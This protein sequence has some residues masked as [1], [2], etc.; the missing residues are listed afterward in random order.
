MYTTVPGSVKIAMS[1]AP[2][3]GKSMS[4]SAGVV[5][6]QSDAAGGEFV[7]GGGDVVAG[8]AQAGVGDADVD[9]AA[10]LDD[11]VDAFE[12]V[13]GHRLGL[14]D[15]DVDGGDLGRAGRLST[16]S[17][18]RRSAYSVLRAAITARAAW[19]TRRHS[20]SLVAGQST[21]G[22]PMPCR[23]YGLTKTADIFAEVSRS[24]TRASTQ[25]TRP[26]PRVFIRAVLPEPCAPTAMTPSSFRL[27]PASSPVPM[28]PKPTG[29]L[30]VVGVSF[31]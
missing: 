24:H 30:M 12:D 16:S 28:T 10:F 26:R 19:T 14:V 8:G 4:S 6:A 20:S 25:R 9:G 23:R 13:V 27:R 2:K 15:A 22:T 17:S 21:R 1:G 18:S 3:P 7:H 31:G 11:E 29:L 5:G